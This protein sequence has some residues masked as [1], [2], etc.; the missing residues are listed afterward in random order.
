MTAKSFYDFEAWTIDGKLKSMA[1]YRG[2]VLLVVNTAS[3]CGF[4]GQYAGLQQLYDANKGDG[5]EVLAFPCNQFLGQEPGDNAEVK[6]FCELTYSVTFQ[7]FAKIEVNGEGAHPLFAFL[8]EAAPGV[9]G[10]T[11][12]KWNF[13]KFL[14][15]RDGRV[16]GRYAPS[17][18]PLDLRGA[19]R[20]LLEENQN[21][22]EY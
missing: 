17:T 22:E 18:P 9:M 3:K 7:L 8:R 11:A 13:T 10:T 19:V 15:G 2:K 14:V 21:Q 1:E 20:A 16:V 5:F 6:S 4:T 12:V